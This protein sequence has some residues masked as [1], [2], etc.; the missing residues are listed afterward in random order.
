MLSSLAAA[1]AAAVAVCRLAFVMVR[2]ERDVLVSP[3]EPRRFEPRFA[4]LLAVFALAFVF[5][6][7]KDQ[8]V[9]CDNKNHT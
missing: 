6:S 5:E 8:C 4:I 1:V 2:A 3:T 9:A 7:P